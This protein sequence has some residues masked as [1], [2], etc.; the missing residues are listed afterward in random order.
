[1]IQVSGISKQF[2]PQVLFNNVSFIIGPR[3]RVGL[4]GR[5][6]SGKSTLF[7]MIMGDLAL[8]DGS[9]SIP[10][11]YRLGFLEQHINF[12]KGS[13]LEECCS[14]LREEEKY[15]FH[16]AE[17]ILS[18]L[19][20]TEEDMQKSPDLF[21]GGYQLRINLAKVLVQRPDMLLLDEPTNYLDIVS[22]R[23]LRNF[24]KS[25]DGEV[26]IITHDRDFMDSVIT[27]TMGI[28]RNNIKKIKGGTEKFYEQVKVEEEIYEQTR[29][30]QEKKKKELEDFVDRFRAKATKAAQAQSRVKML[31]KM[32][33]MDKLVDERTL[34]FRFVYDECK[35]K[36]IMNVDNVSFGYSS[37][38]I[39]INNL[40][41]PIGRNDRIAIIGK[42][43]KGKSTLLN[44]LAGELT[45][46]SGN[47]SSH[48]SMKIGHFGQTNINRLSENS[49]IVEEITSVNE[50]LATARV[51]G[52][53]G[54]MMFEGELAKKK[55]KVL[56]GGERSRVLLGK[57]IANKTNIL[58]LDEPTNHLDMES[59]DS[60]ATEIEN[61]EGAV[62]VVT[63]SEMLLRRAANKLIIFQ[64]GGV[65]FFDGTYDDFLEKVGWEEEIL[66]EKKKKTGVNR[67]ELKKL[68]S[69]II[70]ARSK[71]VGPFKK[72][73]ETIEK[74]IS[75]L[76]EIIEENNN[77]LIKASEEGA[78]ADI[79][80]LSKIVADSETEVENLF[81]RLEVVSEEHDTLQQKYDEQLDEL[82]L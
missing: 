22:M 42:N 12:S 47:V 43:G 18:G 28:S 72:E 69:E 8:D 29:L 76:E 67:K 45:P 54:T 23:W 81:E 37:D 21:S 11:G 71:E 30:N 74:R 25:F 82:G 57:I 44:V 15:D 63:H 64:K 9:I 59:I 14:F 66:V 77:L 68:R 61:Y 50:D 73:I 26:L 27:H 62:L 20:F 75:S 17:K 35:G 51:R 48:P 56:S 31:Q 41:F 80:R 60:L 16:I 36:V 3:E 1:M 33:N 7:K 65:D 13:V 52:I 6:G 49:T 5:N 24:L 46:L 34:G 38:E 70:S 39:L 79:T 10:K 4:V 55:I 78:G 32:D 53:C 40:S 58:M 2:G 19:G